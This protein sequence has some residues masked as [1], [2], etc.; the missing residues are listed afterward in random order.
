MNTLQRFRAR[1]EY[2]T[3]ASDAKLHLNGSHKLWICLLRFR[4]ELLEYAFLNMLS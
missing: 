3:F 2:V 1:I 4:L